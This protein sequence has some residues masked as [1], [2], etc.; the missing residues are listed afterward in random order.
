MDVGRTIPMQSSFHKFGNT[1]CNSFESSLINLHIKEYPD[2]L[3]R[4]RFPCAM[5]AGCDDLHV[6]DMC[7]SVQ[8]SA[9]ALL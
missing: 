5:I 1:V 8:C 6:N 2:S 9:C 3:L 7:T 4:Y